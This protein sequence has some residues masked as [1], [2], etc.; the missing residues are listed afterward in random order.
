MRP[1]RLPGEAARLSEREQSGPVHGRPVRRRRRGRHFCVPTVPLCPALRGIE[2]FYVPCL[3]VCVPA[4]VP[5][6][7]PFRRVF[8]RVR[9]GRD[10][11][12]GHYPYRSRVVALAELYL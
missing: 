1:Q 6:F 3:P 5:I 4:C 9:V 7:V 2:A 12:D 8:V 10:G 11:W